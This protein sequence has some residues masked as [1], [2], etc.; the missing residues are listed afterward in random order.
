MSHI[1][2][3]GRY[4][5]EERY[6][7]C[8]EMSPVTIAQQIV[9]EFRENMEQGEL[10]GLSSEFQVENCMSGFT[11]NNANGSAGAGGE[12]E[13]TNGT[14]LLGVVLVLCVCFFWFC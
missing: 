5:H 7:G 9:C 10:G 2:R 12:T 8:T 3:K 4:Q 11:G 14:F 13:A 1:L 6:H